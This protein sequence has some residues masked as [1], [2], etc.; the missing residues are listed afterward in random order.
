MRTVMTAGVFL[1]LMAGSAFAQSAAPPP[2]PPPVAGAPAP[3]AAPPP[4][5]PRPGDLAD[6][7]GGPPPPP[8]P[9][10]HRP[11]PPPPP[12]AAHFRFEIG[13]DVVDIKCADDESTKACVDTVMP[14]I[15]RLRP[16]HP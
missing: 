16:A 14:L 2:P 11:P 10:G 1:A 9:G 13:D 4:P 3:G 5:P 6:D 12:K 8:P 7:A 15:D